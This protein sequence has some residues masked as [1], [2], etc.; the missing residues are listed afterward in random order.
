MSP[1]EA[2]DESRMPYNKTRSSSEGKIKSETGGSPVEHRIEVEE[3]DM[4]MTGGTYFGD[5]PSPPDSPKEKRMPASQY[6]TPF[7][8]TDMYE[9]D[10]AEEPIDLYA[11]PEGNPETGGF[12]VPDSNE[13]SQ[14]VGVAAVPINSEASIAME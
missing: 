11:T 7:D 14:K 2:F 5:S 10:N 1:A 12:I 3:G 6:S 8:G 4:G 9:L 13:S